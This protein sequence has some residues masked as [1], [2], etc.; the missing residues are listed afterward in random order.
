MFFLELSVQLLFLCIYCALSDVAK[1]HFQRKDNTLVLFRC[2]SADSGLVGPRIEPA[3]LVHGRHFAEQG[4]KQEKARV[5]YKGPD[6]KYS[7]LASLI[8][9]LL[10]AFLFL[11][12][13]PLKNVKNILSLWSHRNQ[14]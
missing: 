1:T 3:I 9:S 2:C 14:A 13:N 11:F 8:L 7:V 12:G 6:S 10:H 4:C 5:F